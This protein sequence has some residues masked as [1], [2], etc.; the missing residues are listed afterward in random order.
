[1]NIMEFKRKDI[2]YFNVSICSILIYLILMYSVNNSIQFNNKWI[3]FI[4][5]VGCISYVYIL[6]SWKDLTGSLISLYTLFI[7]FFYLFNF[8][9]CFLWALNIHLPGE[10]GSR[11]LY[12]TNKFPSDNDILF[13]QIIVIISALMIHLGAHLQFILAS[14]RNKE[15]KKSIKS[16]SMNDFL[17]KFCLYIS[18]IIIFSVFVTQFYNFQNAQQY[19]YTALYYGQGL[20]ESN[21]VFK[22]LSRLFFPVLIGLLIGSG[23]KKKVMVNVYLIFGLN[24]LASISIGDR[25]SWIYS[26]LIL[27]IAHHYFYKK[28]KLKSSIIFSII[29]IFIS[30]LSVAIV[31]IRNEGVSFE[32]IVEVLNSSEVNP[33]ISS[34]FTMGNTMG[35]TTVLVKD[36]WDIFPYGNTFLYGLV[37]APSSKLID[38]LNL[39]YE[40]LG[41][42]FSQT[43]LGIS[44]GAGF[45][46]VAEVLLNFG[47][48]ILLIC[49]L[50]FGFTIGFVTNIN[51]L[52]IFQNPLKV[53]FCLV[54]ISVLINISRNVFSYNFGEFLFTTVQFFIYFYI[55]KYLFMKRGVKN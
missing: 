13:T 7:T 25:G 47:P 4:S 28:I 10:I 50:I 39:N 44:N 16:P 30:Y 54:T 3:Y 53:L 17:F 36:G 49:M 23:Y 32:K 8:G 1:M 24:A 55:A 48:V 46:I 43:Y 9:Q 40:S 33:I 14:N 15:T 34:I 51:N 35:I 27:I 38:F 31:K 5:I 41:G 21:T 11:G 52:D 26:L 12:Y 22:L 18:P 6:L 2:L 45:S 42:W 29:V 37:T 20:S 19:G